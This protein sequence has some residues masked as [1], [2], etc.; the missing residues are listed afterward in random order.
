MDKKYMNTVHSQ[1]SLRLT[2]IHVVEVKYGQP[3]E[4]Y[5]LLSAQKPLFGS[6]GQLHFPHHFSQ[7]QFVS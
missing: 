5:I 6:W 1:L 2:L 4:I 3:A 7:C